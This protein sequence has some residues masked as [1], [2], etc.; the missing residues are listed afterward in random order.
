MISNKSSRSSVLQVASGQQAYWASTLF[1]LVSAS[2]P[3]YMTGRGVVEQLM[4]LMAAAF[5]V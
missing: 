2:V 4:W 5:I 1:Q 3:Q